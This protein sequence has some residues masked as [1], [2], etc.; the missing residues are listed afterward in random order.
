MNRR[1]L[2]KLV[3]LSGLGVGAS[4]LLRQTFAQGVRYEGPYWIF[5]S[6]GGGWDPRFHFDPTLNVEQNTL[7]TEIGTVGNI[8]FA[9]LPIDLGAF[10]LLPPEPE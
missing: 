10:N 6:A 7:Y 4:G 9:P 1:Q 3:A 2:L 8:N 5:I